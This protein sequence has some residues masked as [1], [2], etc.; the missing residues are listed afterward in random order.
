MRYRK[1]G[2]YLQYTILSVHIKEARG[3]HVSNSGPKPFHL[4]RYSVDLPL[5]RELRIFSTSY[6]SSSWLSSSTL[7]VAAAFWV[8]RDAAARFL[9]ADLAEIGA[10]GVD[11]ITCDF[12]ELLEAIARCGVDKYK[13]VTQISKAEA[14][15]GMIENI[16]GEADEDTVITRATYHFC[17]RYDASAN[18]QPGNLSPDEHVEFLGL[19]SQLKMEDVHGFPQW[20]GEVHESLKKHYGAL[21][22]AFRAY[23]AGSLDGS[24]TEMDMEEFH[25]F[26]IECDLP[27]KDYSFETMVLQYQYANQLSGAG[28][29]VLELQA[30]EIALLPLRAVVQ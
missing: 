4:T 5:G 21:K 25:D 28:D 3:S 12:D 11:A 16:L 2:I 23:A 10:T 17:P 19:W 22:S 9:P 8:P 7:A 27:T 30:R 20:E 6:S 24:A 13:L 29:R 1:T 18:S 26:A 14:V 15:K